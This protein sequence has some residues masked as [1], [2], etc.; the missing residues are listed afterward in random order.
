VRAIV[1]VFLFAS[2]ASARA[3]PGDRTLVYVGLGLAPP[4]YLLGTTIHEGSHA[5]A[6]ELVGADVTDFHVFPPGRDPRGVFRFGWTY[7]RGLKT[8]ND[9]VLFY[10]APK[11]TDALL[12]GGFAALVYTGAWPS[13]RYGQLALTVF[14]TGLWVDYSKD[15]FSSRITNDVPKV[16][17]LWCMHGWKQLP[18]RLVYAATIV[19]A[20]VAVAHGYQRTFADDDAASARI[21]PV[22]GTAF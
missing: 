6:G 4:M 22:L 10:I 18:A 17:D 16:L 3:D 9:K 19:A 8:R 21:V 7:V 2:G 11:L 5:L 12:L 13:N 20:G 1:L 14:G 15:L